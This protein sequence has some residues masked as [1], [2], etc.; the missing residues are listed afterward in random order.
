VVVCR[1]LT[2]ASEGRGIVISDSENPLVNAPLYVKYVKKQEEYRVHVLGDRA[3]DIQR[4]MRSHEVPDE[5]VN[6]QV[7]NHANGFVF[8]RENVSLP[9][10]A[11]R[12][13]VDAVGALGLDFGAVDLIYN[14]HSD[15]YYVLEVNTAPGLVGTTLDNYAAA[16]REY[17]SA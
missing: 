8:G 5:S 11:T 9:A 1:T 4:K 10:D 2:K 12:L 15:T 6:W 14:Q 7:R 3:F 13:A 16:F 17:L